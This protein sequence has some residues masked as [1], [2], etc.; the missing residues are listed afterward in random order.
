MTETERLKKV[1][2]KLKLQLEYR[3]DG[4]E[5]YPDQ[6]KDAKRWQAMRD[7]LVHSAPVGQDMLAMK[8]TSIVEVD[9]WIDIKIHE[10][11]KAEREKGA[12]V[13]GV[14]YLVEWKDLK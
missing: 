5:W 4:V 11:E 13:S 9:A 12:P 8:F 6:Q 2:A 14:P 7:F 1:I 3:D 10:K